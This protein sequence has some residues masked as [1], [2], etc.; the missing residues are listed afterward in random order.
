MSEDY[1]RL[2]HVVT[3]R[4]GTGETRADVVAGD[5]GVAEAHAIE[6]RRQPNVWEVKVDPKSRILTPKAMKV[7][8][9]TYLEGEPSRQDML[10]RMSM[11]EAAVIIAKLEG[12]HAAFVQTRLDE[13][14]QEERYA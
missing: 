1:P 10:L 3:V 13:A 14:I 9:H 2:C 5:L 12:E 7:L 8:A 11:Q 6:L 4:F